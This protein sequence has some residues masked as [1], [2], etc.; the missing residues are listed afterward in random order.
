MTRGVEAAKFGE[1]VTDYVK[2]AAPRPKVVSDKL[3]KGIV[4]KVDHFG[5]LITNLTPEDVPQ[6]FTENPP[7]F[8]F[9]VGKAEVTKLNLAYAQSAAGEVFVM[10]GSS[11]YLELATNRGAANRLLAADRG[12]EVGVVFG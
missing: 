7:A 11:G 10:L 2:F 8:K 6:L 4:L 9:V 5:N 1:M 12:A 3:I